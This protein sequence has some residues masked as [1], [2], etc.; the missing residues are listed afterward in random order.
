M[1]LCD[2]GIHLNK[3]EVKGNELDCYEQIVYELNRQSRDLCET[4]GNRVTVD[5]IARFRA[6]TIHAQMYQISRL[7]HKLIKDSVC[8]DCGKCWHKIKREREYIKEYVREFIETALE[9]DK[10]QDLARA[11]LKDCNE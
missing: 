11:I 9:N 5:I 2:W 6:D 7:C 8:L 10:R 1:K 4:M 3:I